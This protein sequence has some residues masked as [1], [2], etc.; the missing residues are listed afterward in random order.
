VLVEI[1]NECNVRYDHAILKPDRVHELIQRVRDKDYNG[2]RFYV[3]TSYGGGTIPR[4]NV[5]RVSDFLLLHGNGVSNPDRIAEMVRQTR[6]VPGYFAKPILFNEDDHFD[7]DKPKNNFLAAIGEYASWGYFDFRMKAE[8]F[9]EG[10]QSV[11]VNWGI[12]S[13]RKRGFFG[14]LARITSSDP[15][16]P[17]QAGGPGAFSRVSVQ[18][19]NYRGWRDSLVMRNGKVEAVIVPAIGRVM[20]FGFAGEE[21]IFWENEPLFGETPDPSAREWIN[22][23]GDKTWPAPEG[24]WPRIMKRTSWK[25]PVA[26]D[27]TNWTARIEGSDVILVSPVDSDFGIRV[28][29]RVSLDADQPIMRITTAF[30]H[31][32]GDPQKVSVWVVTQL[33]EPDGVFVELPGKSTMTN[34]Y[35]LLGKDQPPSLRVRHGLISMTRDAKAAYKIGSDGSALVWVGPRVA[36]RVDSSRVGGAEYPDKGSSVEVYTNPNPLKYIE[37]ETLGPLHLMTRGDKIQRTN[38]YTLSRRSRNSA[39]AEAR[40]LL[41]R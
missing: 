22:F 14:L 28:E 39:E 21:G 15:S 32:S 24:D 13:E 5:V 16:V 38:V 3:G 41:A 8:G 9:D 6:A 12:S 23:G 20:Q 27:G 10:Y 29:R 35:V 26:F 36:M 19:Q 31:A 1:N 34:G 11:P 4:E 7:F 40:R 37:L 33:K 17:V 25:P 18:K 30:E 2:R